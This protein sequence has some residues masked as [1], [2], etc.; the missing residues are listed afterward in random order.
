MSRSAEPPN[1]ENEDG[2]NCHVSMAPL[3]RTERKTEDIARTAIVRSFPAN[4]HL[5]AVEEWG[6][7]SRLEVDLRQRATYK[8]RPRRKGNRPRKNGN[9]PCE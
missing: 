6:V 5:G 9:H 2:V 7:P 1:D 3:V 8:N 4:A